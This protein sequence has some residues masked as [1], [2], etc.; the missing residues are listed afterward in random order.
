MNGQRRGA[1]TGQ[2][3]ERAV[4]LAERRQ[5]SKRKQARSRLRSVLSRV[6]RRER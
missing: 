2:R 3:A 6:A 5:D 4:I 1:L